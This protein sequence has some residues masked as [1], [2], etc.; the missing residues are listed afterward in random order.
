MY[1]YMYMYICICICICMYKANPDNLRSSWDEN[2]VE[3]IILLAWW[4]NSNSLRDIVVSCNHLELGTTKQTDGKDY[5]CVSVCLETV[6]TKLGGSPWQQR[7]VEDMMRVLNKQMRAHSGLPEPL[8]ISVLL[9]HASGRGWA[10]TKTKVGAR[11]E[12][13][14]FGLGLQEIPAYGLKLTGRKQK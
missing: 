5:S 7:E 4:Q 8:A 14:V 3:D 12:I 11:T 10:E 1:M 2:K 9:C 6:L 13:L